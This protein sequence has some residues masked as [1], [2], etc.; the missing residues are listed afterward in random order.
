MAIFARIS[1]DDYARTSQFPT[2]EKYALTSQLR[3]AALSVS[4]NIAEGSKRWSKKDQARFYEMAF[5]S[6]IEVLSHLSVAHDINLIY[7]EELGG[8]RSRIEMIGR[9][10]NG[11]YRDAARYKH[12]NQ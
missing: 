12:I 8:I 9:M 2:E 3:R 11:L 7:S 4:S 5:G 6:Q 10:L 1:S